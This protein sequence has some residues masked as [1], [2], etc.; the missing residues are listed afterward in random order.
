MKTINNVMAE[1]GKKF[2]GT[3]YAGPSYK[4]ALTRIIKHLPQA[5]EGLTTKTD[6]AI[7]TV[8]RLERELRKAHAEVER[9]AKEEIEG[10]FD[11]WTGKE[12]FK[13]YADHVLR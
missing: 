5:G 8:E 2:A 9:C 12:I 1:I 3:M 6:A 7:N 4:E 13:A 11:S 10:L